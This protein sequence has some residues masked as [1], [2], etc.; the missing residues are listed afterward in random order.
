M[1]LNRIITL[2][3]VAAALA[4]SVSDVFAQQDNGN[5]NGG[6]GGIQRRNRQ[7]GGGGGQGGGNFDP[8]A[9]QQ[10]MMDNIRDSLNFTND[11]DWSAVQP[12]VQK[13][14]DARRDVGGAG[15]RGLFGRNRGG[16]NNGGN[17]NGGQP[18]GGMFGQPS[19]EQDA[20]QKA[21]DDD[22]P[23]AQVKDLLGKYKASQVA[24]QAKLE[25][26][27]DALKGV[28]TSKQEAQAYML[29]LVR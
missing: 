15:M 21:L 11:T 2:C 16:N 27:Q 28:L 25:A 1:K 6:Q 5:N 13:V 23:A 3:A 29:G 24:K 4:L 22:A 14:M 9:M 19:P 17:N 18:R 8:A 12:L 7:G 20:L 10:R 26:A